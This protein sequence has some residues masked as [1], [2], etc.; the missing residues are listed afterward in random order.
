[1]AVLDLYK[2]YTRYDVTVKYKSDL[3]DISE[4]IIQH[5]FTVMV[6]ER[7][8][9]YFTILIKHHKGITFHMIIKN[10]EYYI[11][12]LEVIFFTCLLSLFNVNTFNELYMFNYGIIV[13]MTKTSV[14]IKHHI[15]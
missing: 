7:N 5:G 9:T 12:L 11:R 13:F 10:K 3:I 6:D 2:D 8:N 4:I 15:T 1:M 14:S